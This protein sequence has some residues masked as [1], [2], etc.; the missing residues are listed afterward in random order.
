MDICLSAADVN[1]YGHITDG[2][3]CWLHRCHLYETG[4]L[5]RLSCRVN[6]PFHL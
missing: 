1:G 2:D 4:F 3:G 6:L 5:L